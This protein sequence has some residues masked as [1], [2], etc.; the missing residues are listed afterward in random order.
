MIDNLNIKS[1]SKTKVKL[2]WEWM[3][4]DDEI[5]IYLQKYD[6]D[7]LEK[8][9]TELQIA[10]IAYGEKTYE[11]KKMGLYKIVV[12]QVINGREI[13]NSKKETNYIYIGE[14]NVLEYT[15]ENSDDMNCYCINISRLDR[16]IR[17][18]C[19][20]LSSVLDGIK[21]PFTCDL[22][23]GSKFYVAECGDLQIEVKPPLNIEVDIRRI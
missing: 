12:Y 2:E 5:N 23:Q 8:L 10:E 13:E 1:I 3:D 15:F 14:K 4:L 20:Y 18:E 22:H 6:V 19:V 11:I 21:I 17:K 9:G 7:K 16:N